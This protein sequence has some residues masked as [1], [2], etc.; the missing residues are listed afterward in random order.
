MACL[1]LVLDMSV[2]LGPSPH[3]GTSAQV[4]LGGP[5]VRSAVCAESGR[6]GQEPRRELGALL[7][8]VLEHW[9]AWWRVLRLAPQELLATALKKLW[10]GKGDM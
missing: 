4:V 6:N 9:D 3:P 5:H 8:P 1:P 7:G 10:W 2:T